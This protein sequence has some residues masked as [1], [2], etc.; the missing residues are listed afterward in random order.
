ML[1]QVQVDA[2]GAVGQA[3]GDVDDLAAQGGTAGV[4]AGAAGQGAGGAGQVVRH[5]A[6]QPGTIGTKTSRWE[7]CQGAVDE[8]R[9]SPVRVTVCARW[10]RSAF[11][12]EKVVSVTKAW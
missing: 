6:E 7:V 9:R 3:D 2:V 11:T 5:G 4:S 10:V 12:V 1:G 8:G